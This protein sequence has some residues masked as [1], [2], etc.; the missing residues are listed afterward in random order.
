MYENNLK[1]DDVI[2]SEKQKEML[3]QLEICKQDLLDEE[4][5]ISFMKWHGSTS[6]PKIIAE[7]KHCLSLNY[8]DYLNNCKVDVADKLSY[9]YNLDPFLDAMEEIS[10]NEIILYRHK[11]EETLQSGLHALIQIQ[12][13]DSL[14]ILRRLECNQK[15]E[16][17]P[18]TMENITFIMENIVNFH[19]LN[20][21][22]V[23]NEFYEKEK[24]KLISE[25]LSCP[26]LINQMDIKLK[27]LSIA[28]RKQHE[29]IIKR[30]S[31]TLIAQCHSKCSENHTISWN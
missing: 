13:L 22:T 11:L 18:S 9:M 10:N 7:T 31:K 16:Y 25:D 19:K 5:G 15:L 3:N 14:V 26:E 1:M 27:A 4:Y 6:V 20:A 12:I 17:H 28:L 30:N 8:E 24:E 2:L 21:L 23:A 29:C